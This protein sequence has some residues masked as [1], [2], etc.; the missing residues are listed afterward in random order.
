MKAKVLLQICLVILVL[1]SCKT[2]SDKNKSGSFDELCTLKPNDWTCKV[3]QN[4]FDSVQ[5]P[6]GVENPLA[7]IAFSDNS[8]IA[9]SSASIYLYVYDIS[10][11]NTLE[12]T[13][14]DSMKNATCVPVFFGE[15]AMYYVITSS[16][17]VNDVFFTKNANAK[18][19]C[20]K[21][22]TK[23]DQSIVK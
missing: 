19:A 23:F 18:P 3:V 10:K 6:N 17:F 5:I 13:I 9:N 21:I 8:K 4:S 15:N 1:N 12:K 20:S 11:K 16:C 22:F 14:R 7:V 2:N